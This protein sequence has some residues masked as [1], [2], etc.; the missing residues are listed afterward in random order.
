MQH[1]V[2]KTCVV[3]NFGIFGKPFSVEIVAH[4]NLGNIFLLN[5]LYYIFW[6]IREVF[7]I[8]YLSRRINT[9]KKD[10][11]PII[12]DREVYNLSMVITH[13][14]SDHD[15]NT[16][17]RSFFLQFRDGHLNYILVNRYIFVTYIARR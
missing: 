3:Y 11:L 17:F 7:K 8:H 1:V 10:Q 4:Y 5:F 15:D 9:Q 12:V 6:Q 2:F 13:P 14:S 16:T